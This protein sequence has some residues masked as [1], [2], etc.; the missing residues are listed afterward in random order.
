MTVGLPEVI[1]SDRG[2]NFCGQLTKE[3]L[4]RLRVA[5]QFNSPLHPSASGIIERFHD[6]F[7]QML[8]FAMRD[9]GRKLQIWLF[10]I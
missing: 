10:H 5:P 3:V 4:S 6:T 1:V 9:F 8:H 7:K 2:S